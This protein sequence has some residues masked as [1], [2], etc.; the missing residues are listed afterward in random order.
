[1]IFDRVTI[2]T[3][4]ARRQILEHGAVA[5]TG[6]T[7]EAVGKSREIVERY[8]E[9]RRIDCNG[10][11]LMPGLID[12]HVHLAQCMLR[13]IS[14]R[15][16]GGLFGAL[17]GLIQAY[18]FMLLALIFIGAAIRPGGEEEENAGVTRKEAASGS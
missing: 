12:T 13:G 17:T 11:L 9:K 7:I 2:L 15:S 10:N 14:W 3:M 16:N 4:N 1:M 8:P 6:Q 5:V 18:V